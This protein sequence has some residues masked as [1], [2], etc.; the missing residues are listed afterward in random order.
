MQDT[1]FSHTI[2]D[3]AE[4]TA[5][6]GVGEEKTAGATF[7]ETTT[8]TYEESSTDTASDGNELNLSVVE[9]PLELVGIV[10][11]HTRRD[12]GVVGE[13][14]LVDIDIV[15]LFVV[16]FSEKAH[17]GGGMWVCE[18]TGESRVTPVSEAE[19]Q[20]SSGYMDGGVPRISL[21]LWMLS[22]ARRR[23]VSGVVTGTQA[24][25]LCVKV[26]KRSNCPVPGLEH[27]V[28]ARSGISGFYFIIVCHLLSRLLQ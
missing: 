6:E 27:G 18:E 12:V 1:H 9:T 2:V 8:N 14:I 21:P 25:L 22:L 4:E 15:A 11:N 13:A 17:V 24:R 28:S 7:V 20:E 3:H 10:H 26:H 16:V 19:V 5:V 23:R